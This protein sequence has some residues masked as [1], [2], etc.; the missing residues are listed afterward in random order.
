MAHWRAVLPEGAMLDVQYEDVVDDIEAQAR[1][2]LAFCGLPWDDACLAFHRQE[3]AVRTASAYQ[4]RQP[5]F[6]SS[7]ER[8]RAYERHLGPLL[9]ALW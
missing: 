4:V 1:R 9:E 8:W 5:L 6:R 7:M 3:G 2:M